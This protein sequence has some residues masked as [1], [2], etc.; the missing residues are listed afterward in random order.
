MEYFTSTIK[1]FNNP[2]GIGFIN[3]ISE[4]NNQDIFI[5]YSSITMEGFKTLKADETVRFLMQN[6]EKGFMAT[7]VIPESSS[8]ASLPEK[9]VCTDQP[10]MEEPAMEEPAMEAPATADEGAW[11]S[12]VIHT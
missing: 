6:G 10:L 3:P 8:N 9:R 7:E 11:C 2:K 12:V 1:W 4:S 5:H